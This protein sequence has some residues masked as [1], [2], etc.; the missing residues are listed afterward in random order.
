MATTRDERTRTD[1]LLDDFARFHRS[2]THIWELFCR[3]AEEAHR[4]GRTHYSAK[5]VFERI[6]WHVEV[7]TQGEDLKL[8]N[9]YTAHYARMFHLHRPDMDGFFRVRRLVSERVREGE[10]VRQLD[11]TEQVRAERLAMARLFR[12]L[13]NS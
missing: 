2:N 11:E 7:E 12:I 3:F 5:A 9:N 10:G 6:R 8:N 1:Q 13:H 4:T